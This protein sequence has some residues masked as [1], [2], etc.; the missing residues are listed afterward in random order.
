MEFNLTFEFIK[1]I[2]GGIICFLAILLMS[3]TRDL[4]W[5]L[6]ISAALIQYFFEIFSLF[7]ELGLLPLSNIS[8]VYIFQ[9]VIPCILIITALVIKII[10]RRS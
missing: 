10:K 3:K 7:V 1:V 8:I 4:E 6:L 9:F 2:V 5:M